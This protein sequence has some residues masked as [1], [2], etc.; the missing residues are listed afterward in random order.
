MIA[1]QI[2]L[3]GEDYFQTSFCNVKNFPAK[4][5]FSAAATFLAY[6]QA[7]IVPLLPF[8]PHDEMSKGSGGKHTELH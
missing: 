5:K 1:Y 6:P 7:L 8:S 4:S 3:V 2:T